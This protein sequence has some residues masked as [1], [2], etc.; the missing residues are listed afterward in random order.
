MIFLLNDLFGIYKAL[1]LYLHNNC[2]TKTVKRNAFLKIFVFASFLNRKRCSEE[3]LFGKPFRVN[4]LTI[5]LEATA[6]TAI[7]VIATRAAA[8]SLAPVEALGFS[9]VEG[10]GLTV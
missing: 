10:V 6:A 8:A 3:H 2:N 5:F 1:S 7:T 9:F 4:Y